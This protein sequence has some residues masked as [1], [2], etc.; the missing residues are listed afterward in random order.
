MPRGFLVKRNRRSSSSYRPRNTSPQT[1]SEVTSPERP[2]TTGA[3]SAAQ[4]ESPAL[5]PVSREDSTWGSHVESALEAEAERRAQLPESDEPE[6]LTPDCGVSCFF[7]PPPIPAGT[8]HDSCS[9]VKPVGTRL[10]EQ[11]NKPMYPT[12]CPVT[13]EFQFPVSSLSIERLLASSSAQSYGALEKYE[14]NLSGMFQQHPL[15][16]E[17][18]KR[19][20]PDLSTSRPKSAQKKSKGNKKLTFEDE[21]TTSPVLGLQIKKES[22]EV[23]RSRDKSSSQPLGE[24]ICQLCKEEYADPFALA[25]HKCCRIVRVEY[26]CPEC[27]KVF[28]CPANLASH[29]RWHKPRPAVTNQAVEAKG[30]ENQH[31]NQ[32][33]ARAR[34]PTSSD[35]D[36][37][38]RYQAEL[39]GLDLQQQRVRAADS[40]PSSLLLMNA[41]VDLPPP[42]LQRPSL[43]FLQAVPEEEVYDCRY[44][45]KKFR[46]RA[47]LRK[48]L[49]A[50]ELPPRASPPTYS[51]VFVCHL[52]G[53]RFPTAEIRD[54]HRLW[55][56][57]R[58]EV[59]AGTLG[60]GLRPEVFHHVNADDSGREREPRQQIFTCTHC[61]STFFSPTGLSRHVSK[62]H[63]T[64]NRSVIVRDVTAHH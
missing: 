21:V 62:F 22:P 36:S 4:V 1:D 55:H 3:W 17:A 29:R 26:R 56:E 54:K 39:G 5:I 13:A 11:E 33:H 43:S 40:P 9:P 24:F 30:K 61:L 41:D 31:G 46:R 59:L 52:C 44:C 16:H 51:Q 57:M 14:P 63:P 35:F 28:S 47:F 15:A 18:R 49:A 37:A 12:L 27:D 53:A 20:G 2:G 23:K 42:P 6:V 60:T 45:G 19:E 34:S 8:L 25:Q 32:H 48:H 38:P 58:G 64:Q 7:S 50:H 10:P